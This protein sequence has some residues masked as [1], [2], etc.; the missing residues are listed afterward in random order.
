MWG[1]AECGKK[2]ARLIIVDEAGL[3]EWG[4]KIGLIALLRC[5]DCYRELDDA[6]FDLEIGDEIDPF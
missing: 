5:E 2:A 6:V 3:T 1:G 4:K